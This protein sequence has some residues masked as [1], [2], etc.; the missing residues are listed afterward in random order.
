MK[1]K[2]NYWE[3]KST[4]RCMSEIVS[5]KELTG[6]TKES[7]FLEFYKLNKRLRYCN[8]SHYTFEEAF[9]QRE[10]N[11]WYENLDEKTKFNLFYSG[12]YV[13]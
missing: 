9:V 8:G 11:E 2:V 13:D 7:I 10:Y 12:T 4:D 5:S 1:I 3:P 6:E